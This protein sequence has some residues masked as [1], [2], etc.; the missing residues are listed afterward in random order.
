MKHHPCPSQGV[1]RP[2]NLGLRLVFQSAQHRLT[3]VSLCQYLLTPRWGVMYD[4]NC[5]TVVGYSVDG[6]N[7]AWGGS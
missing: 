1:V 4:D 3:K 2:Y 7:G 5:H 6:R